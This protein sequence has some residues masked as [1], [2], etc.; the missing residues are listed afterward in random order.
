MNAVLSPNGPFDPLDPDDRPADAPSKD[1]GEGSQRAV[2]QVGRW[3]LVGVALLLGGA[4]LRTHVNSV[5]ASQVAD[6]ARINAVRAVLTTQAQA[7]QASRHVALPATLHGRNEAAIYA[8]TS[9]YVKD[10]EKDIGDVVRK[11]EVLL[12]I[13]TPEVDQDLAQARAVLEQVKAR[14]ALAQSSLARWED[15]RQSK[16]VSQQEVDERRATQQQALADQAA[17]QANVRRLQELHE[18]GRVTAPFDGVVVKRHVD[19]GALVAAGSATIS[20]PLYELSETRELR[21]T[22]GVPQAY[23][24]DVAVGKP[25]QIRLLEKPIHPVQ[26]EITRVSGGIDATTR[27]LEVEVRIPNPDGALLPGAY[28]EVG[29]TL[30]GSP[31]ALLLP[32]NVLQFRQDGPRVAVVN[33]QQQIV[34]K[35]IKLGRDLGKLVE[36]L[37]GL[38]PKDAVVLNPADALEPG[39]KV[40]AKAAPPPAKDA[41]KKKPTN[42]S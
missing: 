35:P 29:L 38:D 11:G 6:S 2:R 32:P 40:L 34:I 37:D 8:R 41:D 26:G 18:F 14:L 12:V 36:V 4:G 17:A 20:K 13:D 22:V 30:R 16:A 21:L 9:G 28:V 33:D 1:L 23:A 24:G 10:W 3:A 25:V 7:T 39:E 5:H 27:A 19:V 31:K 15:L 42:K